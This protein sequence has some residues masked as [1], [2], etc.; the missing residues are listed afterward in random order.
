[1]LPIDMH[2]KHVTEIQEKIRKKKNSSLSLSS[3]KTASN[4]TRFR[5]YKAQSEKLDISH[6]DGILDVDIANKT[7]LVE[8]RV[9]M[10]TLICSLLPYGLMPAVLPEFKGITVGGAI[11]GCGGESSS[12]K[13]GLFH[14]ICLEYECVLG[15]GD[16][17][18]ASRDARSDLFHGMHGSYGSLALLTAAKISLIEAK[19]YV[20]LHYMPFS[21]PRDAV[22]YCGQNNDADFLEALIF[23]KNHAVVIEANLEERQTCP[24][25]QL[26][27]ATAPW[28]YQHA[29]TKH[30]ACNESMPLVDYLFRHDKGAFW[31][32]AYILR[33]KILTD[34][35]LQGA[36]GIVQ[37]E[38]PWLSDSQR[39]TYCTVKDPRQ[40][41]R[42]CSAYFMQSQPLYRL[43]HLGESW[44]SDRFMIQDFTLPASTVQPFLT[45]LFDAC[46][47]FPLWVC[48]VKQASKAELFA[49]NALNDPVCVNIGVYGI[50]NSS[51][52]ARSILRE[53]EKKT[54]EFNGRKWL[55][56]NSEYS[57]D[58][59]WGVYPKEKYLALRDAYHSNTVY[60]DIENKIINKNL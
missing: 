31:M 49:P 43:L 41:M 12:H 29:K 7:A 59:F 21:D 14:D 2:K 8:P 55:Y 52:S 48:P 11:N 20:R 25:L 36:C 44:V 47:L 32:G 60:I 26:Q 39:Q 13:V 53:L 15:N 9:S 58:L 1:M 5:D 23:S 17:V 42:V 38:L 22:L 50:A 16:V 46:P 4:T 40:I 34:F 45:M 24:V 33:P 10:Y 28:F 51:N 19:P 27:K 56:T 37:P 6:L 57:A 54:N 35:L 30:Q 3:A 18:T